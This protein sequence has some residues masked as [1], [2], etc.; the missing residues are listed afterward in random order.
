MTQ[1]TLDHR[2]LYKLPDEM[3][4]FRSAIR[5]LAE[6]RIRPRASEIDRTGIYP[7]D[8]RRLL[9]EHDI[10]GLPFLTEYG[11]TGTGTFDAPDGG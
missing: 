2:D 11:G 1:T 6:D 9:A 3:L 7:S 10:L 8:V 4:D 5:T